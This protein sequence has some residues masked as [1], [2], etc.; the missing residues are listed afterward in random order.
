MPKATASGTS[1]AS[2]TASAIK[3]AITSATTLPKLQDK[4]PMPARKAQPARAGRPPGRHPDETRERI[5]NV[6][7]GLFARNG[8]NGTSLREVASAAE[9]QTAAIGY[10]YPSKEELFDTVVRRRAAVMSEWRQRALQQMRGRQGVAPIALDDL[11]RAYVQ[12]FYESASHGDPG[13][14]N[15]AALMGRLANSTL[16]TEVIARHYDA[17]ARQYLDEFKRAL[18]RVPEASVIDGFTFM[19][20]SMLALC[21]NTGRA[22]RLAGPGEVER[23]LTEPFSNLVMF[24]V[25]GFLA[26]PAHS[27]K[28]KPTSQATNKAPSKPVIEPI[29]KPVLKPAP[30]PLLKATMRASA[31]KVTSKVGAP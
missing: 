20:A 23:P 29:S 6:A 14:R 11:V 9:L 25:S 3:T 19:V 30:K 31:G 2:T 5:L 22:Q 26:L 8:Y 17:T 27:P 13:W 4:A 16:G 1:R 12:P 15:Y 24:L 7:E 28:R 21:A 18:P 10:H